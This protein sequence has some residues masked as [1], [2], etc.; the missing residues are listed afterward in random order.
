MG[1]EGFAT[2]TAVA[3]TMAR[4]ARDEARV[5]PLPT[6]HASPTLIFTRLADA[7]TA[8]HLAF[9]EDAG[10]RLVGLLHAAAA[11]AA[12][13]VLSEGAWWG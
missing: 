1:S 6:A 2:V 9:E 11:L 13:H 5:Y 8:A 7:R 12:R 3:E 10:K 4:L